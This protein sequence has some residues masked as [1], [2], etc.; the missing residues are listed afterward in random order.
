LNPSLAATKAK[1]TKKSIGNNIEELVNFCCAECGK[2][3]FQFD[4]DKKT[5]HAEGLVNPK[6]LSQ[7]KGY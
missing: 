3:I 6:V 2:N 5:H 1:T 4:N 7:K